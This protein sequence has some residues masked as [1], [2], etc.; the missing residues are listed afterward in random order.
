MKCV[1]S[2][3]LCRVPLGQ[4]L[5]RFLRT[6][7]VGTSTI[8]PWFPCFLSTAGTVV[9]CFCAALC[10]SSE[11]YGWRSLPSYSPSLDKICGHVCPFRSSVE[12]C[13]F[14]DLVGNAASGPSENYVY[15]PGD[16]PYER[17]GLSPSQHTAFP[18]ELTTVSLQYS[19]SQQECTA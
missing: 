7:D 4:M 13:H 9:T 10:Q 3:A 18:S 6:R 16:R 2:A 15:A 5:R 1:S 19:P 14:L 12:F 11:S 8:S 17:I